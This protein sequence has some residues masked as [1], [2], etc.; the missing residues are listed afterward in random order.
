MGQNQ[1]EHARCYK[2]N[3]AEF[4]FFFFFF[5]RLEGNVNMWIFMHTY[6]NDVCCC[7]VVGWQGEESVVRAS[8]RPG[9]EWFG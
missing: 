1:G 3:R 8:R 6:Q 7:C 5:S 4:D 9:K 2:P